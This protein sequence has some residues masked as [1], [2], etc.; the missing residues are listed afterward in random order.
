MHAREKENA[1]VCTDI[2]VDLGQCSTSDDA[3]TLE[4]GTII[5]SDEP[6]DNSVSLNIK[7]P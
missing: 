1:S 5:R 2:L 4:G 7:N 3:C 6:L